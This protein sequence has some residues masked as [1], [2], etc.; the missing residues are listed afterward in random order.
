MLRCLSICHPPPHLYPALAI[1]PVHHLIGRCGDVRGGRLRLRCP[2]GRRGGGVSE[3]GLQRIGGLRRRSGPPAGRRGGGQPGGK[4]GDRRFQLAA[5]EGGEAGSGPRTWRRET[6]QV[7]YP[8]LPTPS[9]LRTASS[10]ANTE[11]DLLQRTHVSLWGHSS[12][13]RLIGRGVPG[14]SF[15]FSRVYNRDLSLTSPKVENLV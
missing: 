12:H 5:A 2:C 1:H 4:S 7:L 6:R 8:L 9:I 10:A 14:V 3:R 11:R 13:D 15:C